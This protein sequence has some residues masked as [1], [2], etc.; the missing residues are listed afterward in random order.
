MILAGS[1]PHLHVAVF[2]QPPETLKSVWASPEGV[3]GGLGSL[4]TQA[5]IAT[6]A[7]QILSLHM[8]LMLCFRAT[9][10]GSEGATPSLTPTS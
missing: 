7:G 2:H 9:P 3:S 4:S 5:S 10:W 1:P 6:Q 8:S